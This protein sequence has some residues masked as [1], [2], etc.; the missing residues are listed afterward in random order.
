[1]TVLT[2]PRETWPLAEHLSDHSTIAG[3]IVSHD[4]TTWT[5]D[6]EFRDRWGTNLSSG[7]TAALELLMD[8]YL[9]RASVTLVTLLT[10][11]DRG[12]M[13]ALRDVLARYSDR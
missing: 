13:D 3:M 10:H 8:L 7:E 1:M 4:G 12:Y 9:N 2:L 11:F 5:V 6:T